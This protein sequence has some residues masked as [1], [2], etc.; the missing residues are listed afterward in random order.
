MNAKPFK[1]IHISDLHGNA[2]IIDSIAEEITAANLLV[3]SGDLTHFGGRRQAAE[4]ME[5]VLG[6]KVPTAA[7]PGNCDRRGVAA[8]L[9]DT[10]VSVDGITREIDGFRVCG[11]GGSLP[12]PA[13]TP[14]VYRENEFTERFEKL[15]V[16]NG[17]P[18][19]AVIHQPPVDSA[20]DRI[21]SGVHVGS[22]AVR[23]FI[24]RSDAIVCMTGHI[25][26]SHGIEKI[27]KTLVVN[28]G[29]AGDGRYAVIEI[30]DRSASAELKTAP[31]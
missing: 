11:M 24:E 22:Q 16:G 20:L 4:V 1:I 30:V 12:T 17:P 7:V 21:Q 8:Y 5:K 2:T 26:E 6:L 25:H 27:G 14:K 18:D 31:I 19:I 29:A 28:P 13:P 9:E 23:R 15:I 3:I 10:G